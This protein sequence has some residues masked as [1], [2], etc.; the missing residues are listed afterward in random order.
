L[1]PAEVSKQVAELHYKGVDWAVVSDQLFAHARQLFRAAGLFDQAITGKDPQDFVKEAILRLWD[2][3]DTGVEW[4]E[5]RGKPTTD[6]VVAYLW[7]VIRRDFI[8][9]KKLPRHTTTRPIEEV[10]AAQERPSTGASPATVAIAR[11]DRTRTRDE[12]LA[13]IGDD[14]PVVEYLLLQITDE[15][16]AG[17]PPRRAAELLNTS[18]DDINNRKKRVVRYLREFEKQRTGE[19]DAR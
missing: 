15:G 14:Q 5:K 6:G 11:V 18:I 19:P 10:K 3:R 13:F 9:A 2:P 16:I 12:L 7:Q 4:D 8:D 1:L 17:Y